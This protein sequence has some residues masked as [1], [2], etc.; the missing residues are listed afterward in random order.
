MSIYSPG[1]RTH[2]LVAF[3][4][5][6]TIDYIY[7][8]NAE[9][10]IVRPGGVMNNARAYEH[11]TGKPTNVFTRIGSVGDTSNLHN[12]I[13]TTIW[14]KPQAPKF[15]SKKMERQNLPSLIGGMILP[16][17]QMKLSVLFISLT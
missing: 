14:E 11:L 3:V 16:I 13:S 8:D 1:P 17:F 15:M 5:N 9:R 10:A 2:D 7:T 12:T 6:T 4:G